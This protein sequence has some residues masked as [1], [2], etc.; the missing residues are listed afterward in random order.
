MKELQLEMPGN[1][2]KISEWAENVVRVRI[3]KDFHETLMERYSVLQPS[4]YEGGEAEEGTVSSGFLKVSADGNG[5][6]LET[7][8]C[9]RKI[10]FG[11]DVEKPVFISEF[12]V[13]VDPDLNA[14]FGALVDKLG[15]AVSALCR[16]V[17]LRLVLSVCKN[18][19]GLHIIDD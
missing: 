11:F 19:V 3:S 12:G 14:A 10:A 16:R 18:I 15:E 5:I 2:L 7:P 17:I 4:T 13:R 9:H 8:A 6:I 1:T